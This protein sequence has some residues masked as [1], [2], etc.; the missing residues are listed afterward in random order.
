MS[1]ICIYNKNGDLVKMVRTREQAA[2]YVGASVSTVSRFIN[3]ETTK[4]HCGYVFKLDKQEGVFSEKN[5][6]KKKKVAMFVND[7]VVKVYDSQIQAS[8][9]NNIPQSAV[10]YRLHGKINK[11]HFINKYGVDFAYEDSINNTSEEQ[12]EIVKPQKEE[13][14]INILVGLVNRTL[15][16][17]AIYNLRGVNYT[18]IKEKDILTSEVG[19]LDRNFYCEL[20]KVQTPI[21]NEKELKFLSNLLLAFKRENVRGIIKSTMSG[22]EFIRIEMLNPSENLVLPEFKTGKYY[23]NLELHKLYTLDELNL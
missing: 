22:L 23:N 12:Q 18:Y 20:C 16:D 21:L 5:S 9:E 8:R 17:R 19:T 1:K 7:K 15:V 3:G 2:A 14:L 4:T 11:T 10:S 13:F 6:W